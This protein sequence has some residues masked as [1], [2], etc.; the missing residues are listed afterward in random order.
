MDKDKIFTEIQKLKPDWAKEKARA[1]TADVF[2][3]GEPELV[4]SDNNVLEKLGE[5]FQARME[6]GFKATASDPD[7]CPI[8]KY[9]MKP[10]KLDRER[11]A[12]WCSK[13]F[14]VFPNK[15]NRESK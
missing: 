15:A 14:I 8:C 9:P 4:L 2:Y 1:V 13:H 7:T 12:V 11:D 6:A 3:S 5:R 10:V